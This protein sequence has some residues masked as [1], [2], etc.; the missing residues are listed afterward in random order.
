MALTATC[1]HEVRSGG[2]DTAAGGIFDPSQTAGML[3]DGAATSAT[4]NSPVFS[5]ASYNFVAG[6]VGAKVFIASGTN[7]TPGWYEIASVA[8][9][10]ATLKA[11]VGEAV[12][13]S[14]A[15]RRKPN[16]VAGCATV[17]SPTNATW[18]IDYSQQA[19]SQFTYTDITYVSGTTFTSATNPFGKQ[20]VG[21]V[22]RITGGTNFT[23]GYYIIT[24]VTGT[25]ATFNATACSG[26]SSDGAGNLGGAFATPGYCS[27]RLVA[28]N[29]AFVMAATYTTTSASSNVAGGTVAF[30]VGAY[31]IGYTTVRGDNGQF[32][33]KCGAGVGA[34]LFGGSGEPHNVWNAIADGDSVTNTQGFIFSGNG[35]TCINCTA[36]NM[37][38]SGFNSMQFCIDCYAYNCSPTQAND[39]GFSG[40]IGVACINCVAESCRWGFRA[41]VTLV[42]CLAINNLN[43]GFGGQYYPRYINCTAYGN[44]SHG[45]TSNGFTMYAQNC[46]S[47]SNT[48]YG[49]NNSS[50]HPMGLVYNCATNNN[51]SGATNN[52]TNRSPITLSG[53][54]FTNAAGGDFSLD[55]TSGE[56]AAL[57]GLS[58]PASKP[59]LSSTLVYKDVGAVQHQDSGGGG[60]LAMPVS[61]PA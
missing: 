3:T 10:Q 53:V 48:G 14:G 1:I 33:L 8:T 28:G 49:F 45:F 37:Q 60:G 51:S 50:F 56:G 5:S 59:G 2:S 23:T 25:T 44:G 42:D 34:T 43:E 13:E 19:S 47:V 29:T 21:N 55:N 57:R 6:D 41:A 18:T 20:Q 36:K 27:G 17:A 4:G 38:Y 24:S 61:G 58:L 26:A 40:S 46:I 35:S 39:G 22:V 12:S 32:T 11:A 15:T 7:W 31:M 30:T 9:N 52:I 16:T 54:P